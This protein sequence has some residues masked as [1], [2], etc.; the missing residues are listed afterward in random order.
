MYK[1]EPEKLDRRPTTPG[2]VFEKEFLEY[3][4]MSV[5]EVAEHIYNT[6]MRKPDRM[7][8]FTIDDLCYI[9]EQLIKG[10]RRLCYKWAAYLSK[11]TGMSAS[12]WLNLQSNVDKW[13]A[14]N[15]ID[16]TP[17]LLPGLQKDVEDAEAGWD[18]EKGREI[19]KKII[20]QDMFPDDK[21]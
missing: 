7:K 14:V 13:K 15:K 6:I 12:F 8:E 10:K 3:L 2:E 11:L 4:D 9:L 21:E 19:G 5:L 18:F 16:D 17:D 20:E 1:Y